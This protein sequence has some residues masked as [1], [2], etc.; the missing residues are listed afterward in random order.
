MTSFSLCLS[1]VGNWWISQFIF[2]KTNLAK[3]EGSWA[4]IKAAFLK[5]KEEEEIEIKADRGINTKTQIRR[6]LTV[7]L[8][9]NS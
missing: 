4:G 3:W 7:G 9:W 6:R 1:K 8:V 2:K 5:I